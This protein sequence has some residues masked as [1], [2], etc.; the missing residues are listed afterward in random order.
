MLSSPKA[1]TLLPGS[2]V[3]HLP[4]GPRPRGPENRGP[5][6]IILPDTGPM[7]FL[8]GVCLVGVHYLILTQN[9][10]EKPRTR[11]ATLVFH[12]VFT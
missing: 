7:F 9:P 12:S 11:Y 5:V 10:L 8:V 2:S 6:K 3:L 4:Q 1:G